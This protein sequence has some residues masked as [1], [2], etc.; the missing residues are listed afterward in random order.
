MKLIWFYEFFRY[1]EN[2]I[3]TL[4]VITVS[5][6][7]LLR[8]A[9][10]LYSQNKQRQQTLEIKMQNVVR[11]SNIGDCILT[12]LVGYAAEDDSDSRLL[13]GHP[14]GKVYLWCT[15]DD[16]HISLTFNTVIS[17]YVQV[18]R[19]EAQKKKVYVLTLKKN[20]ILIIEVAFH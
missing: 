17:I 20:H 18:L 8:I 3:N 6:P 11:I 2:C 12:F 1:H 16:I 5:G 4:D 7:F 19:M 13:I 10:V 9:F 14:T 15:S